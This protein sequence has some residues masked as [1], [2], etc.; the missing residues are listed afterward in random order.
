MEGEAIVSNDIWSNITCYPF[1]ALEQFTSQSCVNSSIS[2]C[3]RGC[4]LAW[5]VFLAVAFKVNVVYYNG[6]LAKI[7]EY[8]CSGL[9]EEICI[10]YIT[11]PTLWSSWSPYPLF[12]Q[13]PLHQGVETVR[14]ILYMG[15]RG[16][17]YNSP[18]PGSF[19]PLLLSSLHLSLFFSH[20]TQGMK[21]EQ[22]GWRN[23]LSII[24][25]CKHAEVGYQLF[26]FW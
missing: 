11:I 6:S 21:R 3:V 9:N 23:R 14:G 13:S 17:N 4:G 8:Y 2:A 16:G 18:L 24:K 10:A 20:S 15:V 22:R 12:I 26:L 5:W 25:V 7:S 1:S 19:L